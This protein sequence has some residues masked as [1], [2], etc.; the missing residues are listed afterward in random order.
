MSKP[1]SSKTSMASALMKKI[2]SKQQ[3]AMIEEQE[4]ALAVLDNH[5]DH[6]SDEN[7]DA[8]LLGEKRLEG[9]K[10]KDKTFREV[11]QKIKSYV[12]WTRLNVTAEQNKYTVRMLEFRLYV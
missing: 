4:K 6:P 9:G 12:E 5:P 7:D 8:K 3:E 11:Y 2:E 1:A 10:H